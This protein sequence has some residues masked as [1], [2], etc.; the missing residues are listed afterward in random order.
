[1][2]RKVVSLTRVA[3]LAAP[4]ALSLAVLAAV[5]A[6]PVQQNAPS[7]PRPTNGRGSPGLDVRAWWKDPQMAK[8]VGLTPVQIQKIDHIYEQRQRQIRPWVDEYNRQKAELDRMMR[9]RTARPEDIEAQARRLTYPHLDIDVSRIRL[10]YEMS[11]VLTAEQNA[12]LDAMFERERRDRDQGR[13]RGPGGNS[14]DR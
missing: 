12:K 7:A 8:E 4:L 11:R 5:G 10:L 13:G 3:P 9:E 2:G 1:V 14:P 6:S